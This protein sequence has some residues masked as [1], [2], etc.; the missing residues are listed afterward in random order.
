ML[1]EAGRPDEAE[2][3]FWEDL[4]RVPETGWALSGLKRAL[5]AQGK[6]DD[7]ALVQARLAKAWSH[8]D[9]ELVPMQKVLAEQKIDLDMGDYLKLLPHKHQTDGF[10]AA[11]LQRKKMDKPAKPATEEAD[12]ED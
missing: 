4:R 3:V 5:E 2:V 11:V 7:A 1:L 9:F 10:F 12:A 8:A 6:T